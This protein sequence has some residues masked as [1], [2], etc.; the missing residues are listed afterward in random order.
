MENLTWRCEICKEERPDNR[1]NVM[2]YFLK[3]LGGA[4]RNLKYCNDKEECLKE[5]KKRSESG[6]I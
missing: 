5:A 6:E 1:I 2:S 3:S 4:T